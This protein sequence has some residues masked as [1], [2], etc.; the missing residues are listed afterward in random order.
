VTEVAGK[1]T[2]AVQLH[3]KG[4]GL[5]KMVTNI[6]DTLTSWIDL[7][8][9]RPLLWTVD[10]YAVRGNDRERTEARL[11]ARDGDTIPIEFHLNDDPP[12]P[13]PQKVSMPD[14]WD[15][16]AFYMVLRTWEAPPGSIVDSEVL[17]SRFLWHV[18]MKIHG[19][20]K[21]VTELGEFP[22]LRLDGISYKLGRDGK[23]IRDVDER[24]F[25]IWISDD[26]DRVPLQ[27]AARTDYGDIK[28]R[29]VDYQPGARRK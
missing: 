13:E 20:E 6:D 2:I 29:L 25:S 27:C 21:L 26:A 15:F 24:H 9:G 4:L 22:A 8:T 28:L 10:E 11:H 12:K 3:A 1:Q 17:R 18:Q 7:T 14:V 5:V 23:R 19:K 16:A